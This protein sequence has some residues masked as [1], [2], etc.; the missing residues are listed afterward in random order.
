MNKELKL[1]FRNSIITNL[2]VFVYGIIL[3]QKAIYI[4]S[5]LGAILSIWNLYSIYKDSEVL[6][7]KKN[8]SMKQGIL[9]YSK[10]YL[11]N[12]VFLAIMMYVDFQWLIAGALGLLVVK[13]NILLIMFSHQLN[14][15][16]KKL[17]I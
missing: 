14:N 17:K 12:G 15:I 2:I 16:I 10:R 1:V 5:T 3:W 13:L 6:I 7:Y 11:I 9:S 8:A 4:A